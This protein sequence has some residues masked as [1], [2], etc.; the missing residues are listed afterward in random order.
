MATLFLHIAVPF[1]VTEDRLADFAALTARTTATVG[2]ETRPIA[3]A[4][5]DGPLPLCAFGPD[6][7]PLFNGVTTPHLIV[8]FEEVK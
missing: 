2:R 5:I 6:N 1:P 7:R 3:L 4:T 8:T